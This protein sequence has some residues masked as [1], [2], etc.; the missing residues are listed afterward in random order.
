[1]ARD[2]VWPPPGAYQAADTGRNP[3]IC[4]NH[5]DA[6]AYVTWLSAKTGSHSRL[7]S[8]AEWE[9]A[10]RATR[11][12]TADGPARYWGANRDAACENANVVDAALAERARMVKPNANFP[13]FR[14]RDNVVYTAPAGSFK[15]NAF[16]L[17]DM[18]GNVRQWTED[19][20]NPNYD[21]GAPA[22]GS[23]WDI[24]AGCGGR[25]AR[26]SAWYDGPPGTRSAQRHFQDPAF[27]DA[28]LGFRVARDN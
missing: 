16:G 1:M 10:A 27:R 3:A 5:A 9:Y 2:G 14:C 11:T 21:G 13:I 12:V 4:V 22:D 8:E 20:A 15:P 6:E 7:P 26:G 17:Y 19:C 25:V 23:A 28:G 18:L 24:G